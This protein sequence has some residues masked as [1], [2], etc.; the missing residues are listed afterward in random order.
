MTGFDPIVNVAIV[1]AAAL[2]GGMIAHRL[3]QPLI[4]GYLLVGVAVGPHGFGIVGDL[5]LIE[6]LATIGVALL[7]FTVG[8]EIS[9]SQLRQTGKVGIWGGITQI[10]ATFILGLVA[11]KLLFHLSLAEAAFFGLLISLSSTVVGLK[12]L[13]ER[14]ELDSVHGRIMI[15]ILIVQDL[16]VVLMMVGVPV[17][18]AS[19]EGL[20]LTFA[21]AVGKAVLFLGVAV[22]LGLWVLPW[23]LGRVAGVRTR[24]LF[25]LTVIIL[26]FGA[27]FGT[28]IFGLSI[29]FGAFV[30][31]L[32]LRES[33]FAH[34]ALAEITPLRDVFAT[35]F[36][37]SLGMLL[38]PQFVV[39]NWSSV[40]LAVVVI[41]V[42]KFGVCFGIAR[43]FGYG[44]RTALFV[45]AGLAQIGEFS[46]I[47]AQAGMNARII[48]DYLYSLV[49]ASM[50]ITML[51]T[52]LFMGLTS[53]L[54][55]R[56]ARG[57]AT[58]AKV[59]KKVPPLV[60]VEPQRPLSE[61]VI[62][63]YGRVGRNI[64]QSLNGLRIP[65]LVI[66][67]DPD[68]VSELNGKGENCIYGD[69]SNVHVLSLAGL[70]K[71][72]ALVVTYPDP[73]VVV[74]TVKNVLKINPKLQ[75]VARV[76]RRRESEL[77]E[78]LGV[79]ELVSPEYEA[80]FEFV[81]R[82]LASV[83]WSRARIRQA[84]SKL[85]YDKELIE[86]GSGNEG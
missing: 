41:V 9:Y 5:D 22:A 80:S 16:S 40:I 84:M 46:F 27:A 4:L 50:V 25:L 60:E 70:D 1:L 79:S 55:P 15:A 65:C 35:L 75:I 58:G 72:K 63:G 62:C 24:E 53:F 64:A 34:Q 39:G 47:L 30:V 76:H 37:V 36:F 42:I 69:A 51:L 56:L 14:G 44:G 71:A 7:M 18:G 78:S 52:P 33:I 12:M 82:T 74:T 3:R 85:R 28:Y 38:S 59:A 20:L 29:A 19:L 43:L 2:V 66:E 23:L 67:M 83:G 26:C 31:G 11:S 13:M 10:V 45:G 57:T 68:I 77:L 73:L 86:F 48:S 17:F 21:I 32:L 81:R 6:T 49:I 54:Y 61:V 8:L